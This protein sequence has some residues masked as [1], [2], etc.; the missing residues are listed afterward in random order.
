[1]STLGCSCCVNYVVVVSTTTLTKHT[2]KK[3]LLDCATK[4]AFLFDNI[5]Y[6]KIDCVSTGSSLALVLVNIILTEF[7]K[8]IVDDVL[9]TG[10]IACYRR[11]SF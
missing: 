1:M 10:T 8:A 9:K 7:E 5:S 11:Y 2:L 3:L 4:T 6:E